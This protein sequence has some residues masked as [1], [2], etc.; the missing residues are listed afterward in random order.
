MS[1][2]RVWITPIDSG[3]IGEPPQVTE[4]NVTVKHYTGSP[5]RQTSGPGFRHGKCEWWDNNAFT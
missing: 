1:G 5:L 2:L 4:L 3:Y